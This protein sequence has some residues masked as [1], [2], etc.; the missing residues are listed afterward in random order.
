[1]LDY[2]RCPRDFYWSVVRP[3]PSAPKPA[4]RL[5]SVV[6]RLLERRARNLP[7]LLDADDLPGGHVAPELIEQ[8][9]RNFAATRYA[10]LPPPEAE[11]GVILRL[12]PWV[13][14]GRIDAIFRPRPPGGPPAGQ[15]DAEVELVDWKTGQRIDHATG[16]LDQLA[17]YALALR[18][19][20][21]LPGDRCV[22][23]YCY[24]GGEE[25]VT[26]TRT[27]DPADL[28]Q[29]RALLEAALAD[30]EQ[31]DYQRA[32][33]LPDCETCRRGLG[34]PPRPPSSG[35]RRGRGGGAPMTRPGDDDLRDRLRRALPAAMKARDRPAVTALRSALAAIDN[36]EAFDPDEACGRGSGRRP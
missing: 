31:G 19:L 3:L 12:G 22:A 18:E 8:A 36:A 32:C 16:G 7:D 26:D 25:P 28:D 13:I 35:V 4:A 27:L 17:I 30:L 6:H 1:M 5:G 34:A 20:G 29:Q 21:E 9:S 23:S 10:T 14:R 2:A 24:L 11:V 33:R 15:E